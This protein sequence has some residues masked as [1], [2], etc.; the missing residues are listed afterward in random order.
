MTG[1]S[2]GFFRA[3]LLLLCTFLSANAATITFQVK[4]FSG[5]AGTN[6][7]CTF[8]QVLARGDFPL[9][10]ATAKISGGA[11]IP[12]QF[13]A[14]AKN[15]DGS[16]R[17]A[18]VTLQ[19]PTL[20]A[21]GAQTIELNP[22][23][24][25]PADTA[26]LNPSDLL[27]TAYDVKVSLNVGGT[28]YSA[29]AKTLLQAAVTA[30][31][32]KTWINGPLATE[33]LVMSPFK[34]AGGTAHP[35]LTARFNIRAYAGMQRVRTDVVIEN[36]WT[37]VAAPAGFTYDAVITVGASTTAFTKTAIPH[38]HHARWNRAV[39]WGSDPKVQVLYDRD[40][41]L[42]TGA[43]PFYDRRVTP[44]ASVLAG[45]AT[46]YA[47]P[48][49]N[50]DLTSYMP[51]TGAH[52]DI[53]PF[54]RFSALYLLSM[55]NN[56][57]LNVIR[58]GSA[59]GSFQIH[60]RDEKT[61]YPVTLESYPY[62]TELG[63]PGDTWNPVTGK[64]EAFP[65]VTNGLAVHTP[66]PSH[67]PSIA[68]LPY[69]ITG[70]YFYLEELQFWANWNMLIANPNYRDFK[71]GILKWDQ[72]RGQAWSLR[73]L[74]QAAYIT[75][76]NHPLKKYFVDR[77]GYNLHY[78]D[79]TYSLP[80]ANKL[81][82]L[83]DGGAVGTPRPWMDDFV[84]WSV[85]YL[86]D[87][88]F[89]SAKIFLSFKAKFP[90]G[91]MT[92]PYCWLHAPLYD[93]TFTCGTGICQDFGAYYNANFTDQVCSG[94]AMDSPGAD[95]YTANLQPGLAQAA[96]SGNPG[97]TAAWAKFETRSPKADY[98]SS[99]QWAVVPSVIK[100]TSVEQGKVRAALSNVKLAASP[101][102]F[103]GTT[104]ISVLG[105]TGA[106]SAQIAIYDMQGRLVT[107][108]MT[109]EKTFTWNAATMPAG[110]YVVKL[111]AEGRTCSKSLVLL[112]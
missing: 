38:T 12:V 83:E 31:T 2:K 91:R 109:W 70:D 68:Y 20:A 8:G 11:A 60:Y 40:Y 69:V 16:V 82:I 6:V 25:A 85:G 73:T 110:L 21:G 87:L 75:P 93:G 62:M 104:R 81:G 57:Y 36:N 100:V 17:H 26:S 27:A 94:T 92:A 103:C 97:A 108:G 37:Y 111:I 3:V 67:Q 63:N 84:T 14:K 18:I 80:T 106:A 56:A 86:T 52:D 54:P 105:Q 79:S 30:G 98:S 90:I 22:A 102:P 19:I 28:A 43:F 48:M 65:A 15:P 46:T 10:G 47:D 77:V 99:P 29:S 34:T 58:N 53:G 24:L 71:K 66:D 39:W 4:D 51:T 33:W 107:R 64:S 76:D 32:L 5:A 55:D 13:N 78:Y 41:L 9:T 50:A 89:D 95:G 72:V 42:S 1:N 59:G 74:G 49:S 88:G 96:N 7:P 23:A 61:D 44:A 101:N 45:M 35:H 112:K